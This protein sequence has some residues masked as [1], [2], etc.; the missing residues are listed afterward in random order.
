LIES[1]DYVTTQSFKQHG[2]LVYL[3]G[4]TKADFN[5]TE[6]QKMQMGQIEGQLFDFDLATEAANQQLIQQSIRAGLVNSVHDLAEG[7]L[8]VAIAESTFDNEIG[9]DIKL[10]MPASWLFSETQSR[11]IVSVPSEL[12]ADFEQLTGA[13]LIGTTGGHHLAIQTNDSKINLDV[14]TA[15]KAWKEALAWQM[16]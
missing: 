13:K 12:Q 9:V 8:A 5:G 15:K 4:E 11:F 7:G 10:D 16:K 6:I 3:V 2:D 14:T 1:M